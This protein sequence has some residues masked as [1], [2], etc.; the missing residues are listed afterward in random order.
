[1]SVM[2]RD[3]F[4]ELH[5]QNVLQS[6]R[7]EVSGLLLET[8][9]QVINWSEIVPGTILWLQDP[10][11]S[12]PSRRHRSHYRTERSDRSSKRSNPREL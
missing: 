2:I 7:A 9:S 1:M 11:V 10:C 6:L 3:T 4:V 5:S 8:D 12:P